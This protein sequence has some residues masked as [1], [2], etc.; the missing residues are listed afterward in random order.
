M[1]VRCNWMASLGSA[2][3]QTV[4]SRRIWLR[5]CLLFSFVLYLMLLSWADY[6]YVMPVSSF[7]YAVV[8]LLAVLVLGEPPWDDGRAWHDLRGSGAGRTDGTRTTE[9]NWHAPVDLPL[10]AVLITAGEIAI[11]HGMKK[12]GGPGL[13]PQASRFLKRAGQR[14]VLAGY[15]A[16]ALYFYAMLA[17]LLGAGQPDRAGPRSVSGGSLW[18]QASAA[19]ADQAS[20]L[21]GVA[22]LCAGVALA[23]VA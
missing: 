22:L 21:G 17:L 19:R 23:W 16:G 14:I 15:R 5:S 9:A 10:V 12:V 18:R 2:F 20:A 3:V 4:V 6:S 13:A 1:D 8:A 7:G 11:T